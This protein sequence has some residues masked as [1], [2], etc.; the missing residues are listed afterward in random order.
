LPK[1]LEKKIGIKWNFISERSELEQ[2]FKSL[3]KAVFE[4]DDES[5]KITPRFSIN[6]KEA[7]AF[8]KDLITIIDKTVGKENPTFKPLRDKLKTAIADPNT[9]T[10]LLIYSLNQNFFQ[11]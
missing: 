7:N 10:A 6:D 11:R 8:A 4:K 9:A 3:I 2:R 5:L 1:T